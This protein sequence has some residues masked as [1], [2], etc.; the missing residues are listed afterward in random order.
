[1]GI[2]FAPRRE[3][4]ESARVDA[5][6]NATLVV[7]DPWACPEASQRRAPERGDTQARAD[8]KRADGRAI[9][10]LSCSERNV[11]DASAVFLL[12][13]RVNDWLGESGHFKSL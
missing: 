2:R 3:I 11:S 12:V 4:P 5:D 1:V 9:G 7:W 10:Q 13:R 6:E 8:C